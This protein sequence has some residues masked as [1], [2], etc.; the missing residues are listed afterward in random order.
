MT[1]ENRRL[2][3]KYPFGMTQ[4]Q[5]ENVSFRECK[6]IVTDRTSI[7]LKK[8]APLEIMFVKQGRFKRFVE[9]F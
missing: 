8:C 3:D 7:T 2:E 4:F 9:S 1:P 5:N 6:T